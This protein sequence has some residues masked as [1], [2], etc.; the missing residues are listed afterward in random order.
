MN[1]T[2]FALSTSIARAT[3]A[4]APAGARVLMSAN[5]SAKLHAGLDSRAYTAPVALVRF[6]TN[7][8][9]ATGNGSAGVGVM[10]G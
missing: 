3:R 8:I 10:T 6:G 4:K 7:P 2:M 9:G 1:S 5:M